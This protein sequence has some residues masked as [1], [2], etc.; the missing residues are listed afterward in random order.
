MLEKMLEELFSILLFIGLYLVVNF[1]LATNF[2]IFIV[3]I[4]IV[5]LVISQIKTKKIPFFGYYLVGIAIS[6]MPEWNIVKVIIIFLSLLL[7]GFIFN[8]VSVVNGP[9]DIVHVFFISFSEELYFRYL[10]QDVL[11]NVHL[12][13]YPPYYNILLTAFI[14][15]ILHVNSY[16]SPNIEFLIIIFIASLIYSSIY[17]TVGLEMSIFVHFLFNLI[18]KCF[19]SSKNGT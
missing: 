7:V 19:V 12:V 17:L 16:K 2:F 4:L 6:I 14:F 11:F 5:G 18:L 1:Y 13:L 8:E 9:F 3:V 10:I 15:T